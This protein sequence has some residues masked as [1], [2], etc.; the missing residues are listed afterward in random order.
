MGGGCSKVTVRSPWPPSSEQEVER[1]V[2]TDSKQHS[3]FRA[4]MRSGQCFGGGQMWFGECS[5]ENG[6]SRSFPGENLIE[7][8]FPCGDFVSYSGLTI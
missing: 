2:Y 8:F 4:V 7:V 3:V 1:V 5:W 6:L